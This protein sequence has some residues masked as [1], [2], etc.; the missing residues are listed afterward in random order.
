MPFYRSKPVVKEAIQW[1]GDNWEQVS[2]LGRR[3]HNGNAKLYSDDTLVI[4][5]LEGDMIASLGDFI[6]IGV[7]GE[8]Y[9]CKPDIFER[10]HEL[11][12]E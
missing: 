3:A 12:K 7:K 5:T 6:V 9:P 10:S 2:E 8:L 11:I 4:V 1:T